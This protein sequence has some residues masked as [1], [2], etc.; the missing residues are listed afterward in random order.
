MEL[1]G[2]IYMPLFAGWDFWLIPLLIWWAYYSWS[3]LGWSNACEVEY[4]NCVRLPHFWFIDYPFELESDRRQVFCNS[5]LY[6]TSCILLCTERWNAS[7]HCQLPPACRAFQPLR[8]PE[9][10]LWN[11]KIP[12]VFQS[13][14][15]QWRSHDSGLFRSKDPRD[16]SFVFLHVLRVRN[17]SLHEARTCGPV[18]LDHYLSYFGCDECHVDDQNHKRMY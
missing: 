1:K 10:V 2:S 18:Y 6:G 3:T 11:P 4:C 9:V 8:E 16:T 13:Q 14:C 12:Q 15:H 17:R 5:P 7:I